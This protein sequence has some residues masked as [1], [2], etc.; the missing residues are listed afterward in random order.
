MIASNRSSSIIYTPHMRESVYE[1]PSNLERRQQTSSSSST[2]TNHYTRLLNGQLNQ[3]MHHDS[4]SL[5]NSISR[6]LKTSLK[7]R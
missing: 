6:T 7:Y 4:S 1:I 3:A 5:S 2:T